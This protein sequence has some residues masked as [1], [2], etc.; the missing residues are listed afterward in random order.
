MARL[1]TG[2]SAGGGGGCGE[3]RRLEDLTVENAGVLALAG[4][5]RRGLPWGLPYVEGRKRRKK[6]VVLNLVRN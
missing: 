2:S 5:E 4:G 3:G 6:W 1:A